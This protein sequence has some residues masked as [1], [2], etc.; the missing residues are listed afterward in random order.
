MKNN[1]ISFMTIFIHFDS[2]KIKKIYSFILFP[3]IKEC[4]LNIAL[5]NFK[6]KF[7]FI[8]QIVH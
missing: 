1:Q 6:F 7:Y 4:K 2:E 5:K 3:I 8:L